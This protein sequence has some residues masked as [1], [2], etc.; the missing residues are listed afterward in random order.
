MCGSL[1][2]SR[3]TI[4]P[5][6]VDRLECLTCRA[7]SGTFRCTRERWVRRRG[8]SFVAKFSVLR[9]RH[10]PRRS[11][12]SLS[13]GRHARSSRAQLAAWTAALASLAESGEPRVAA[14]AA[15]APP[16][17]GRPVIAR[18]T[19]RRRVAQRQARATPEGSVRSLVRG[20]EFAASP[21]PTQ[22]PAPSA[23]QTATHAPT[24]AA[25]APADAESAAPT[26]RAPARRKPASATPS[27]RLG[28][29][30]AA[31]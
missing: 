20:Q 14:G 25:M 31:V 27:R 23:T 15:P 30:A 19:A 6:D 18:P 3:T 7:R 17:R 16:I 8:E 4:L 10:S 2:R 28:A 9:W 1:A 13:C 22:A 26:T 29:R 24:I 12:R 11:Q 5:R 21:V